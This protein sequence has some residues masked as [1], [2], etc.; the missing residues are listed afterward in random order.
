MLDADPGRALP[1]PAT[2]VKVLDWEVDLVWHERHL[3]VEL[4]SYGFH[5][6]RRRSSAIAARIRSS[7]R[8]GYRVLRFTW[9]QITEEPEAVI[10]ALAVALAA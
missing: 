3:V 4:D 9:R 2:N 6:S 1:A 8:S 10:A 5:S 7:S